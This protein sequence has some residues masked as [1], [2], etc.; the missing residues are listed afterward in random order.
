MADETPGARLPLVDALSAGWLDALN[1][2]DQSKRGAFDEQLTR[3]LEAFEAEHAGVIGGVM[4]R[5][6]DS[7]ALPPVVHELIASLASP[8]HQTQVILGLFSIG[9]IV[10]EFVSAVIAPY[11]Q[12]AANTSWANDPTAPLSP[13]EAAVA[14]IKGHLDAATAA[15]EAEKSGINQ[16][17][18]AVLSLNTGEPPGLQQLQEALRRGIIDAGRF[19]TGVKESRVR[20]EWL[21]VLTA[22]RYSPVN[23]GEVLAG[24]VQGHLG[25][26]DAQARIALAGVDPANFDWLYETHGRPPGTMEMLHLLNRGD[27][28]QG[29]VEQAIRESDVKNKYI[30]ALLH[31]RRQIMPMRTIVSG[32]RQG[33]ISTADAVVKLQQ[34]GYNAEDAALLA[35]EGIHTKHQQTKDL[36]QAQVLALYEAAFISHDE[37]HGLIAK[38]GFDTQ[39]VDW[40]LALAEHR[41]AAKMQTAAITSVRSQYVG[42]KIDR[43][44]ASN[45]LDRIG[46]QS[47]GRDDLLHVWDTERAARVTHLTEAQLANAHKKGII[48]VGEF[49]DRLVAMGYSVHDVRILLQLAGIDKGKLPL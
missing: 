13:A 6:L 20:D 9:A 41:R 25:L 48:D 46:V 22:L 33:V 29:D 23:P 2:H 37:A 15:S 32:V 43:L 7:G 30:D 1:A 24:A 34:L 19:A 35:S 4:Q 49:A 21:D 8:V 28:T 26:S 18:F 14:V 39:E 27:V 36:T 3:W 40:L 44:A 17:R 11:V 47:A 16:S 38:L 45:A 31:L 5:V 42:H 12:D 10:R